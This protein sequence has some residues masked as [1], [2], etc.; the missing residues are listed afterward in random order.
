MV[1]SSEGTLIGET[2]DTGLAQLDQEG[3]KGPVD[4]H[5]LCDSFVLE[6]LIG[7]DAS[8]ITM[9]VRPLSYAPPE[10][11]TISGTLDD[12][13]LLPPPEADKHRIV[14]VRFGIP[15]EEMLSTRDGRFD[16]L[17]PATSTVDRRPSNR[18]WT[19]RA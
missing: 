2:V 11:V 5:V 3:F 19:A 6:S 18:S 12:V 9:V 17:G 7:V 13:D 8:N 1:E 16:P 10:T 15:Q 4:I 14:L